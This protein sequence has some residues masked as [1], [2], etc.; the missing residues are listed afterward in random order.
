[1]WK[2]AEVAATYSSVKRSFSTQTAISRRFFRCPLF[3]RWSLSR[4][5]SFGSA[6]VRYGNILCA[7]RSPPLFGSAAIDPVAI[8]PMLPRQT[9]YADHFCGVKRLYQHVVGPEVQHFRPQA[10]IRQPGSHD[11]ERGIREHRE[12]F[13]HRLP[14]SRDEIAIAKYDWNGHFAQR[15]ESRGECRARDQGPFTR[16]VRDRAGFMQDVLQSDAIL[17]AWQE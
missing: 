8:P 14:R 17:G 16:R 6:R 12:V 9:K 1:M 7:G 11:D 10:F 15:G 13:Q 2:S 3:S 5:F 4:A